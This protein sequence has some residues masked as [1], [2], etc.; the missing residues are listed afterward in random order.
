M[1]R[2]TSI[3]PR[4][5]A[6]FLRAL[7]EHL[8]L[9]CPEIGRLFERD[10][11]TVFWWLRE[12]GIA[13]RPRGSDSRQHFK[14]GQRSTFAGRV[15]DSQTRAR[16]GAASVGRA[17]ARGDAHWLRGAAPEANPNWKG[18]ATPERQEFYRSPEWKSACVAVWQRDDA[19][20][21]HCGLDWRTVDR[22]TTPTF[23]VHYVWSFQIR[24]TRANPALLVLLCRPCHLWVHSKANVTRAW[25][26]QEP[27]SPHLLP[28][29]FDAVE[30]EAA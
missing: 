16:I 13:T 5:P 3:I 29:L 18:G 25:L 14:L 4:P 6:E 15:H 17:W 22:R 12:A 26:P 10:A 20:C 27:D 23:H 7:Y 19:C 30:L 9:G 1:P 2:T 28:S 24:E 8:H 11:K 21:R